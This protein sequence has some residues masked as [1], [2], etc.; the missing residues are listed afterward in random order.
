VPPEFSRPTGRMRNVVVSLV[1]LLC[2]G[3]IVVA[4]Q[5]ASRGEREPVEVLAPGIDLETIEAIDAAGETYPGS[6][7]P[8]YRYSVIPG[9]VYTAGELRGAI[10]ADPVVAAHYQDL[11]QSKL[12]VKTVARDQYAYVSYRK[13][14]KV[15]WTKNKVLL[16]QG[17]TIVTDGTKQI[18]GRCGNCISEAPQLPTA[19]NEPEAIEFDRLVDQPSE[20]QP[21][22]PEVALVP[23]ASPADPVAP[24]AEALAEAFAPLDR[25]SPGISGPFVAGGNG[26]DV[27]GP[28]ADS[29]GPETP[30]PPLV[31]EPPVIFPLPPGLFPTPSMLFPTPPGEL[32]PPPGDIPPIYEPPFREPPIDLPPTESTDPVPVPEPG[33]LLLIAAGVVTAACRRYSRS[34]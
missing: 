24:A 20:P 13:G 33:T 4:L 32:F 29:P 31:P 18:R 1:V 19:D 16:R 15:L 7:R 23:L 26:T 12:Q 8:V 2:F 9:G 21:G 10:Q 11:E 22:R 25:R 34:R 5:T 28:P 27:P 17:E 30:L 14:E 6:D 3:A